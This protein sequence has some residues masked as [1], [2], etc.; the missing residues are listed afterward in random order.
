MNNA[1]QG[2]ILIVDDNPDNLKVLSEQ[3]AELSNDIRVAR[4]GVAAWDS[5][6]ADTPDL[7]L[8]DI[9]MPRM[10]GYELCQKLQQDEQYSE[11]PIIFLSALNE[12][13]N[14]IKGFQLGAVDY[15]VKPF[16]MEE[17]Q[18]RVRSHLDGHLYQKELRALQSELENRVEESTKALRQS[19]ELFRG[20]LESSNESFWGFEFNPP[21]DTTLSVDEQLDYF[22]SNAQVVVANAA[23]ARQAGYESWALE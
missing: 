4:D 17:V 23:W 7:I 14:K 11:I 20:Y 5:I 16:E 12:P 18:A 9:L 6:Q 22:Y 1:I 10:D 21:L 15:I 8:L 3:L 2:K 19:D 13:F